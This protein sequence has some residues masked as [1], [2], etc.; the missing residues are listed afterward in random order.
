MFPKT[1][2]VSYTVEWRWKIVPDERAYQCLVYPSVRVCHEKSQTRYG[3]TVRPRTFV[4]GSFERQIILSWGGV[5]RCDMSRE[6]DQFIRSVSDPFIEKC[7][8]SLCSVNLW[9][10]G[11]RYRN[12]FNGQPMAKC[13]WASNDTNIWPLLL[14]LFTYFMIISVHFSSFVGRKHEINC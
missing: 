4:L 9:E 8:F 10:N 12:Y 13:I 5:K 3:Q 11:W 6:L 1:F 2:W 14:F 7:V